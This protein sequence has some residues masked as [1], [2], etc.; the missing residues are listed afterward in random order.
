MSRPIAVGVDGSDGSLAA[1]DWA[2]DEAAL[3]A[4]PLRLVYATQWIPHQP[5]A[6][7]MTHEERAEEAGD[8]LGA[9]EE[10]ARARRP[11]LT[12]AA[13]EVE[14]APARVLL[15]AGS[16]ADILVVGTHG[17]SGIGGFMV[18]SVGQEVVADAKQPVV[19][20]RPDYR[21]DAHGEHGRNKVVLGLDIDDAADE[22]L[23]FAFDYAAR[24]GVPLHVLHSWHAPF[25]H[26]H[27][28][29]ADTDSGPRAEMASALAQAVRPYRDK[30]P[31]V[32]VAE[33]S[34]IGRPADRLVEEA[35]DARLVVLG[36]RRGHGS[37]IGSTT[38][39]LIHHAACPVTV[40]P[41]G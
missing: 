14:D 22:V 3:R 32:D 10:R 13:E 12:L 19:L 40:V 17:L 23:E 37:H 33:E 28:V 5:Q 31:A 26:R 15:D 18:G 36:R 25:L 38:H 7:R 29:A 39:A 16:E 1:V 11:Q 34:A 9:M 35:A 8:V 21:E 27:R 20:V 6:V 4:A 30:Y 24:R 2:A 41:H